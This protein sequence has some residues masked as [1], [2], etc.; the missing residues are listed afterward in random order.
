MSGPDFVGAFDK[1]PPSVAAPI[2]DDDLDFCHGQDID[3]VINVFCA[4]FG[5]EG[6]AWLLLAGLLLG[7]SGVV[8]VEWC[9]LGVVRRRGRFA[10]DQ[11]EGEQEKEH[12]SRHLVLVCSIGAARQKC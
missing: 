2:F 5:D 4:H 12:Y 7:A 9:R 11:G 6:L 3:S 8:L 10:A 1:N